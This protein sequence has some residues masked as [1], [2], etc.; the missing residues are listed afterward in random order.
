M[1]E[2]VEYNE[3]HPHLPRRVTRGYGKEFKE[4]PD[5]V[6]QK[7]DIDL[8]LK[9]TIN[10]DLKHM[11]YLQAEIPQIK[12][13]LPLVQELTEKSAN[14]EPPEAIYDFKQVWD[15][16]RIS[17]EDLEFY[18]KKAHFFFSSVYKEFDNGLL[19]HPTKVLTSIDKKKASKL[20]YPVDTKK[21]TY[22]NRLEEVFIDIL[23]IAD[24]SIKKA[25]LAIATK[26][27]YDLFKKAYNEMLG[28]DLHFDKTRKYSKRDNS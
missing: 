5:N 4:E 8:L 15:P 27:A 11:R 18:L 6:L 28:S 21:F 23:S 13:S 16:S 9:P 26:L 7:E 19:T 10:K 20:K 2:E 14:R 12:E 1:N 24:Y 3:L 22:S 17:E 25:L